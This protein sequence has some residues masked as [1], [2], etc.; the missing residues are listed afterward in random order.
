MLLLPISSAWPNNYAGLLTQIFVLD[1]AD[2]LDIY[3]SQ[4]KLAFDSF[5]C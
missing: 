4:E 5:Y 3:C 2:A 1:L